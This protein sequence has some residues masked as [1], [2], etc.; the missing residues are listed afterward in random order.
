MEQEKLTAQQWVDMNANA[1]VERNRELLVEMIE[2]LDAAT[3][4]VDRE[5]ER[6]HWRKV[7]AAAAIEGGSGCLQA[8]A[9][10]DEMLRLLDQ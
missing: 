6:S 2:R 4:R 8:V 3:R 1:L 7:F 9:V 5:A 10:A